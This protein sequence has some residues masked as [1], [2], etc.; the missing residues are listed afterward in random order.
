MNASRVARGQ[1]FSHRIAVLL[2]VTLSLAACSSGTTRWHP[3]LASQVPDSTPVRFA[4]GESE[5][6]VAGLALDWERGPLRVVTTRGDTVVVPRGS[7]LEVR[8]KEKSNHAVIGA[9]VGWAV[10]VAVSYA[11]CPP[12]K[13]YCGEEDPRPLLGAGLGALVGSRVKTDWWVGVR[14]DTVSRPR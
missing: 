11:T 5:R 12:P 3:S 4:P 6:Q 14:W 10:G 2:A 7:A 1:R 13:R 9:V 8:L